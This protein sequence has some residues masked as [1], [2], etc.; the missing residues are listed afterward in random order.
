[1]SHATTTPSIR[2]YDSGAHSARYAIPRRSSSYASSTTVPMAIPN[3]R[4]S[5]PPP[6]PPP[7]HI[8]ALS[9]GQDPGWQWGNGPN[10]S[11][12]GKNAFG[13]IKP[14]SS[15]LGGQGKRVMSID[16]GD[17]AEYA[18][19]RGSSI[20]TIKVQDSD[21]ADTLDNSD[22]DRPGLPRPALANHSERQLGQR[23]LENSSQA[24]D[25]QLLSKIGGPNTPTRGAGPGFLS[26]SAQEATSPH[27]TLSKL[28]GQLKPLSMP[29]RRLS[30][31]DARWPQSSGAI[32]PGQTDFRSPI[33]EPGSG[34]EIQHPRAY[35][36]ISGPS[37]FDELPPHRGSYSQGLLE[38]DFCMEEDGMRDLNLNDRSPAGSDEYQLSGQG[39]L[40]RRASSP[41][42]EA[43]REDRPSG[44]ND[45]YHRR[46]A[47]M[48]VNRNSPISRF[49]ANHGSVSSVASSGQRTGSY[50][51]SY[52]L[53]LAS[54]ATSYNADRL[55]PGALS[56]SV[57]ADFGP[58]VSPY[59]ANRSLNP[60]PRGSLSQPHHQRGPSDNDSVHNRKLSA[61]SLAH[62]RQSSISKIQGLYIC[63]CCPKK[64]KKFDSEE[65]L[66]I[67]EMEKQYS[68]QYCP[69][70]FKNK[71]EAE[72]HQNSLHLRRHSWSCAALAGVHAAFHPS[73]AHPTTADVCGYCGEEF[74]NPANWDVRAE[75]LNHV[76]KFG[77]CNQ[78]KKFFRADHFRQHLKHSHAGTS[79]KWTN[80]LE[81]A[82]MKDEPPPNP[83]TQQT[84]ASAL[85]PVARQASVISEARDES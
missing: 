84:A 76:H 6:L 7:R 19:R 16:E 35:G 2:I 25:K 38:Q 27:T 85:A 59:A 22:E 26:T 1:M 61:D 28:N 21:M 46:S 24:Y 57:D 41:P 10:G 50:A 31:T 54:S 82:C 71:N 17:H 70:R 33:Y 75:H 15:L 39:G 58:P 69:N 79:G 81:N 83:V 72:R 68:C 73:T 37:P 13:S 12:F 80:M 74:P 18:S 63:E 77:E 30:A 48:L 45:L 53:S 42:T 64:P 4:D 11:S 36:S 9:E 43:A 65:E 78:A 14:G 23:S 20:S 5:E 44:G 8:S 34:V 51:S 62:S 52:G 32:S 67:H 60:S 40:K 3:A 55:S 56:P 49:H 47:Q 66:R 29:E